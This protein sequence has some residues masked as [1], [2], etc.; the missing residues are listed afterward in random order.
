M[1]ALH[2]KSVRIALMTL[3]FMVTIM[4]YIALHHFNDCTLIM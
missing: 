3:D 4:H 1:F 2:H